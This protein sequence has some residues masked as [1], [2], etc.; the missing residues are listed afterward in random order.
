MKKATVLSICFILF[1]NT[2]ISQEIN[3]FDVDT[4]AFPIMKAKFYAFDDDL[5]QLLHLSKDD[6]KLTENGIEREILS[7]YCPTPKPTKAISSLLTVDVSGSMSG[8][9]IEKA[10]EAGKAWINGLPLGKSECALT[11]FSSGNDILCDFTKDRTLLLNKLE[12][13]FAGGGTDY[14]AGFI[15]PLAGG[16]L[17][18][19]RGLYKKV[20]VFLTDGFP[21]SEPDYRRIIDQAGIDSIT[22][23][24]V[25]LD[26]PCPNCLKEISEQTGGVWFE[27][28]TTID[29]A[30]AVYMKILQMA[31][32]NEPCEIQWKSKYVCDKGNVLVNLELSDYSVS[33]QASYINDKF[34]TEL[35]ILPSSVRF[36]CPE[37]GVKTD[38]IISVHAEETDFEITDITSSNP[39]FFIEPK[40]FKIKNGETKRLTLSYVAADS[41]Y[42]YS[43]FSFIN[44]E[45]PQMWAASGGWPSKR[46]TVKTL[47]LI[48]PNGDE[49]FVVGMDTVITWEGTLSEEI[50]KIEYSVN[51]GKDWMLIEEKASGL[52]Y[53]W[54]VP[55]TPSME[56]LARVVARAKY[57]D[58]NEVKVKDQ[59]WDG[60]NLEVENYRNND[61][62]IY[63]E[64]KEDWKKAG[65]DQAGAWCY[66]DF[67]PMN[68]PVYGKLYNWY[69][70][71]DHRGLAPVGWH[72]PGD[73]E[74]NLLQTN[75]G[76]VNAGG[77]LKDTTLW[78]PPNEGATNE[79]EFG[80]LPG[81][82]CNEDGI[83]YSIGHTAYFWTTTALGMN[84]AYAKLLSFSKKTIGFRG[85]LKNCGYSIRCVKD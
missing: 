37:I 23:Y 41:G 49:S 65:E 38:T 33:G 63:C 43:D 56:C 62:L 13:V 52:S 35:E 31:Q 12:F 44:D 72:I 36:S 73:D 24:S 15:Y 69:A 29:E 61:P 45:C 46:A 1:S 7:I 79:V 80:A 74:W 48:H 51:N 84:Q 4:S 67:N 28:V 39:A 11:S 75:I 53:N 59:V 10:K 78:D 20:I 83:F 26:C 55:K 25:T 22:I 57:D 19:K 5:N 2:L 58:C 64:T 21:N 9:R 81:G 50:V 82:S 17:I 42:N 14:E 66:Y 85:S 76:N 3:V 68:G 32:G 8:S 70:V 71:M 16:I 60:C 34:I 40:S 54:R 77:K 18:A 6:L 27:N 30:R 47:K